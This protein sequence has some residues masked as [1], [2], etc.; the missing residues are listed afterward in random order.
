MISQIAPMVGDYL[1]AHGVAV[2]CRF[3]ELQAERKALG[4]SAAT[5]SV[6]FAVPEDDL[7]TLAP[8]HQPGARSLGDG[9]EVRSLA[10]WVVPYRVLVWARTEPA[11]ARDEGAQLEALEELFQWVVRA[12]ADVAGGH[13]AWGAVRR[14][15]SAARESAAG[16]GLEAALLFGFP[17][18]SV[19]V[20]VV[21]PGSA[22]AKRPTHP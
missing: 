22:L 6:V 21:V 13:E 12:V 17:L 7:G 1:A 4:L 5:G 3:G 14:V 18:V 9:R 10:N 11:R 2:S 19:P 16:A 15:P 8:T 20:G